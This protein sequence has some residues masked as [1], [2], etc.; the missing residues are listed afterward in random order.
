V[1]ELTK[2]VAVDSMSKPGRAP[3][4]RSEGSIGL[5]VMNEGGIAGGAEVKGGYPEVEASIGGKGDVGRLSTGGSCS[6]LLDDGMD[7]EPEELDISLD[8]V[9]KGFDIK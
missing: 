8:I 1:S 5:A 3:P 4:G 6:Q 9:R 7:E 2:Y